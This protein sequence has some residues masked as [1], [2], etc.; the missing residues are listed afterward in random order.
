MANYNAFQNG[1]FASPGFQQAAMGR[2]GLRGGSWD[3]VEYE[4]WLKWQREHDAEDYDERTHEIVR[5]RKE[6]VTAELETEN[7]TLRS[8]IASRR[9][10]PDTL[11]SVRDSAKEQSKKLAVLKPKPLPSLDELLAA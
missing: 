4:R 7:A 2:A 9:G 11:R 10:E 6:K 5:R 3:R 1:A 8:L